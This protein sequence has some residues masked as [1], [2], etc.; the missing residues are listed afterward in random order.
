MPPQQQRVASTPYIVVTRPPSAVQP[1]LDHPPAAQRSPVSSCPSPCAAASA[2]VLPHGLPFPGQ[3]SSTTASVGQRRKGAVRYQRRRSC[4]TDCSSLQHVVQRHEHEEMTHQ[5]THY[6]TSTNEQQM[7]DMNV[8]MNPFQDVLLRGMRNLTT[9]VSAETTPSSSPP[10]TPQ[11]PSAD[12]R[13]LNEMVMAEERRG[14]DRRG[15]WSLFPIRAMQEAGGEQTD[16]RKEE[17]QDKGEEYQG[18]AQDNETQAEEEV[19]SEEETEQDKKESSHHLS[20]QL[21]IEKDGGNRKKA[22]LNWK[23]F[24]QQSEQQ[25][26]QQHRRR[27]QQRH[28]TQRQQRLDHQQDQHLANRH[29]PQQQPQPLQRHL[30]PIEC[31]RMDIAY[32]NN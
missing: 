25:R 12:V 18:R 10:A 8:Q 19:E 3:E 29:R 13:R 26:Y 7:T 23:Q 28:S 21:P 2:G 16:K 30:Q 27:Q 5:V 31:N 1:V 6:P 14:G 22:R 20:S 15:S 9:S 4:P 11:R 32:L 17:G 24:T